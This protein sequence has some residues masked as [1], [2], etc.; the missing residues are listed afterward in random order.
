M[1]TVPQAL[2]SC[3]SSCC[4][5][6]CTCLYLLT[7]LLGCVILPLHVFSSPSPTDRQNGAR[8]CAPTDKNNPAETPCAPPQSRT[9]LSENS[10]SDAS[11]RSSSK[12]KEASDELLLPL[13]K[14]DGGSIATFTC[15]P[16]SLNG[17]RRAVTPAF[18]SL[19]PCKCPPYLFSSMRV[20]ARCAVLAPFAVIHVLGEERK[21]RYTRTKRD[22]YCRSRGIRSTS[23]LK[24]QER[25]A[26]F[27]CKTSGRMHQVKQGVT[28]S[29]TPEKCF[30]INSSSRTPRQLVHCSL[31]CPWTHLT[32]PKGT[33]RL[34]DLALPEEP[35]FLLRSTRVAGRGPAH[36]L[37]VGQHP[38]FATADA[39]C[40]NVTTANLALSIAT[41]GARR[42][43]QS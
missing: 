37:D 28:M 12:G 5:L 4:A 1:S 25:N 6:A 21:G 14:L 11:R 33:P 35:G 18:L 27:H 17:P 15:T 31:P 38:T 24:D 7:S 36:A 3:T 9:P 43:F 20:L 8:R 22:R 42:G 23:G 41:H 32:I 16:G 30:R 19:N 34:L 29:I 10:L 26:G 2:L 40:W 39:A 13:V